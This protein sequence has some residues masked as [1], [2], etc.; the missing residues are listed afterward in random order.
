MESSRGLLQVFMAST[1]INS[2]IYCKGALQLDHITTLLTLNMEDQMMRLDMLVI[3]ET[4][5]LELMALVFT[6][7]RTDLLPY[8]ANIQFW[9][10]RAFSTLMRMILEEVATL[11]QK[12]LEMQEEELHVVLLEPLCHECIGLRYFPVPPI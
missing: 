2:V 5:K 12:L 8:L 4:L 7:E 3:W 11:S 1:S 6:V 9:V 10:D